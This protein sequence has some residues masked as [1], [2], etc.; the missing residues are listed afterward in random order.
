MFVTVLKSRCRISTSTVLVVSYSVQQCRYLSNLEFESVLCFGF[1]TDFTMDIASP[2]QSW[3]GKTFFSKWLIP[4][5]KFY[6]WHPFHKH[7]Q[8]TFCLCIVWGSLLSSVFLFNAVY[9]LDLQKFN[10]TLLHHCWATLIFLYSLHFVNSHFHLLT[11]FCSVNSHWCMVFCKCLVIHIIHIILKCTH[12]WPGV[13]WFF[14]GG[15]CKMAQKWGVTLANTIDGPRFQPVWQC[16]HHIAR[17]KW[18]LFPLHL[19]VHLL[20]FL[21][22]SMHRL[23]NSQTLQPLPLH[24]L[25]WC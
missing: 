2:V 13:V 25:Y 12:V 3:C 14:G 9:K 22:V 24:C 7:E 10:R 5:R 1:L 6:H 23:W 4:W 11:S 21:A 18:H 8:L 15:G 17:V 20:G 16:L 19:F